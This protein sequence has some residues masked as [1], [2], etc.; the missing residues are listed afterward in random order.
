MGYSQRKFG[1]GV[2]VI[3]LKERTQIGESKKN[4]IDRNSENSRKKKLKISRSSVGR[5]LDCRV[6]GGG[7]DSWGRTNTQFLEK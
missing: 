4:I 2:D 7:F 5:A 6:G 1:T 3:E